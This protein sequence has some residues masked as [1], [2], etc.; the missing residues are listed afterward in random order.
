[1]TAILSSFAPVAAFGS[2]LAEAEAWASSADPLSA[3][4]A[5]LT[6]VESFVAGQEWSTSQ[7]ASVGFLFSLV[8]APGPDA[9]LSGS[10]ASTRRRGSL[11][12]TSH[13][14]FGDVL[15]QLMGAAR[16]VGVE[17]TGAGEVFSERT[18]QEA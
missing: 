4:E 14:E 2:A 9:R 16:L 10:V 13:A 8:A 5:A 1:M 18:S 17:G 3:E 12:F 6:K 15:S 11:A 7:D